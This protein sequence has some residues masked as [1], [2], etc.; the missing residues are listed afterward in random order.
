MCG[1]GSSVSTATDYGLDGPGSNPGGDNIFHLF[2]PAL[3]PTQPPVQWLTGLS[4]GSG[5][6]GMG[7]THHHLVPKVLEKSRAIP[8]LTLRAFV[9]YKK[10]EN[11]PNLIVCCIFQC[12]STSFLNSCLLYSV[13][14]PWANEDLK[15]TQFYIGKDVADK[16]GYSDSTGKGQST[17]QLLFYLV[18]KKVTA[19]ELNKTNYM[20]ILLCAVSTAEHLPV[21]KKRQEEKGLSVP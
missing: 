20:D 13:Y 15:L 16:L 11:L 14:F 7:L 8:L 21:L 18:D 2:R 1:P 12:S 6:R 3:G 10:G 9:A 5:G 19:I 17:G 4:Q